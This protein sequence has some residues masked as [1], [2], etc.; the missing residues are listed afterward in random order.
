MRKPSILGVFPHYA[1]VVPAKQAKPLS[2]L[3]GYP[4]SPLP[5]SH[6]YLFYLYII[7]YINKNKIGIERR[8]GGQGLTI[9]GEYGIMLSRGNAL[10]FNGLQ[11]FTSDEII[12]ARPT[13]NEDIRRHTTGVSPK[14]DSRSSF[15][16][17]MYLGG[18]SCNTNSLE[19]ESK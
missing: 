13:S 17:L 1:R 9:G 3:I 12:R 7:I 19:A 16:A 11:G 15:V 10:R 4:R 2:P 14:V 6:S 8:T 5:R 18:A